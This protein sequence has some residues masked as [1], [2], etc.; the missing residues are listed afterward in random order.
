MTK[1]I[2]LE[3]NGNAFQQIWEGIKLF[4]NIQYCNSDY[5]S[6]LQLLK[7]INTLEDVEKTINKIIELHSAIDN[8][9][10]WFID[11]DL[12]LKTVFGASIIDKIRETRK[13]DIFILISNHPPEK[14]EGIILSKGTY[15]GNLQ[16]GVCEKLE[17]LNIK[18]TGNS[19]IKKESNNESEKQFKFKKWIAMNIQGVS[20]EI[21]NDLLR[22]SLACLVVLIVLFLIAVI[23]IKTREEIIDW[24]YSSHD[25][26]DIL[27]LIEQIVLL[28]LIP[29]VIISPLIQTFRVSMQVLINND[30][31][32]KTSN[33]SRTLQANTK[34]LI[35]SAMFTFSILKFI[36]TTY[37]ENNHNDASAHKTA[38][39]PEFRKIAGTE[40]S[41]ENLRVIENSFSELQ[42]ERDSL[43]YA[44]ERSNSNLNFGSSNWWNRIFQF[45]F[46]IFLGI[47]TY[48][49][50]HSKHSDN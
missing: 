10:V 20:S 36:Q 2:V 9:I 50:T 6:I 13:N 12:G 49:F 22:R 16:F 3:N 48:K 5:N 32:E 17:E 45:S 1:Y 46:L 30:V 27:H 29:S 38:F 25:K 40:V 8:N 37:P 18:K 42:Y 41:T 35:I 34:I 21:R 23:V 7:C 47:I 31:S 11:D 14:V 28:L 26:G 44:L 39:N 24:V 43:K 4:D 33:F 19:R 15:S